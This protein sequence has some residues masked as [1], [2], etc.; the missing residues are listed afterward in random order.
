MSAYHIIPFIST[1][2]EFKRRALRGESLFLRDPS[3]FNAASVTTTQ[4]DRGRS[5]LVTNH[6]K[7]TWFAKVKRSING[8][9]EIQ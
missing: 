4:L 1:K 5:V 6:P 3:L 8:K 7:R 2:K 9:L